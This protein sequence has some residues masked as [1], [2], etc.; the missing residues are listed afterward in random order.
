MR[1]NTD[2]RLPQSADIGQLKTRLYEIFRE[3]ATQ[4]N[5]TSEGSM[6]GATNAAPAAPVAGNYAVGD[7]VRNSAPVELGSAGSKYI[8]VGFT[9][10]ASPLT[11]VQTRALTGN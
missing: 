5:A 3:V 10:V 9:C 2:P 11:F 8:V 6:R 4:V 1:L 7:F